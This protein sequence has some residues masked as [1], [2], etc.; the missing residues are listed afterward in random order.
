MP[1]LTIAGARIRSQDA[2]SVT[3]A[4]RLANHTGR[5][6]HVWATP[7]HLSY[8]EGTLTV[9]LAETG[10]PPAG[11]QIISHH[12]RV[13]EQIVIP[14]GS[15]AELKVRVPK[16]LH[17]TVLGTPGLG[18]TVASQ[19]IGALSELDIMVAYAQTPFQ[20]TTD[21]GPEEFTEALRS[22]G[23]VASARIPVEPRA[24]EG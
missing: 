2:E 10:P 24:Q 19:D 18:G 13:P 3:L 16:T 20:P 8:A 21:Q 11:I 23:A 6:T 5:T 15:T 7:R 1:E 4:V 9:R 22:H 17:T 14:A 12:P